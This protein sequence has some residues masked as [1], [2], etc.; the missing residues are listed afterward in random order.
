MDTVDS[1]TQHIATDVMMP[2][3]QASFTGTLK[4]PENWSGKKTLY[5]R[6]GKVSANSNWGRAMANAAGASNGAAILS[7]AAAP[8]ELTW[9]LDEKSGK[10][11]LKMEG[12]ASNS[13]VA[14]AVKSGFIAN[15]VD[16]GEP[17]AL[18]TAYHDIEIDHRV[19]AD[20]D[21]SDLLDIIVT[22]LADNKDTFKLTCE[23]TL[24]GGGGTYVATLPYHEQAL[25]SRTTQTLTM[26]ISALVPDSE[27]HS[28]AYVNITAIGRDENAYANNAFQVFLGGGNPLHFEKQPEDVTAQE[29]EDVTFEVE[30]GG[31]RQPYTYQ[32]QVWDPKHEKWV[33]LPGF[34]EPTLSR[35]DIEKKWDGA[36]FRRR[37]YADRQPGGHA[38][39]SG[40]RGYRRPQSLAA[41]SGCGCHGTDPAV[42]DEAEKRCVI[43]ASYP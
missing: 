34:T 3:A 33:D 23:V 43:M 38:D 26:P 41:V 16:A 40:R 30:V 28:S 25:A 13:A 12:L 42:V 31:G 18:Q 9:A 22:N 32:W 4:I 21:G 27:A 20:G 36:R 8:Q 1:E 2:G 17:V 39:H 11:V 19:Y 7:N 37:G 6:V 10:L 5:L 35:R 15:E 24:D 29:G 14:N